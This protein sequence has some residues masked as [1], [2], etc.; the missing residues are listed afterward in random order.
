LNLGIAARVNVRK[1]APDG[2][3]LN[4][5]GKDDVVRYDFSNFPGIGGYA[6]DG[7]TTV[8]AG[9]LDYRPY[10]HAVFY[11]LTKARAGDV[12]EYRR[13]D[14]RVKRFV[15]S[16]VGSIPFDQSLNEYLVSTNPESMVL[17][18]CSGS[19]NEAAGGYDQ[20]AIVYAVAAD[21]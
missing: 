17:M 8:L 9:H 4:S 12:I 14:G 5:E 21:T 3:M 11:D 15:V 1:V 2:A 13:A 16:W 18:T 6:G 20:R 19:F 7:G 10:Y